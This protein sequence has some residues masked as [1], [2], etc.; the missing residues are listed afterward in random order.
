MTL[1]ELIG[2][3]SSRLGQAGIPY[4]IVGSIASSYHGEPRATRD[5]DVV[6]DPSADAL[7]RF[8]ASVPTE[9]FYVDGD[10]A[11]QALRERG[12]FN[13]IDQASGWKVDLVI[14]K[15]RPFSIEEFSRRQPAELVGVPSFV[16]TAED[17]IIAKLE[18]AKRG[19]SERQ[20]RDVA[21]MI[22]VGGDGLDLGY[23]E[24][25]VAALELHAEW[26]A[27]TRR[28]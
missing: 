14:R 9:A 18:W 27:A 17:I 3:I 22:A 4:M 20:L 5:L 19:E 8:V 13:V 2:F 26:Q 23:L 12:Q 7:R 1:A 16:A 10:S 6:I 21:A 28:G 11:L 25:W 24:R 15:D